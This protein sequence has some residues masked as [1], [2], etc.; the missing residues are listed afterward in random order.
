MNRIVL[1][2]PEIK[3]E[4]IYNIFQLALW[5][6]FSSDKVGRIFTIEYNMGHFKKFKFLV[7]YTG[8][9]GKLNLIS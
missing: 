5:L 4:L 3:L 1:C 2:P 7:Q 9:Y 8:M 6:E